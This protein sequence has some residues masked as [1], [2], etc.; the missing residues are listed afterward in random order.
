ME[1]NIKQ[2]IQLIELLKEA[3]ADNLT[4]D[5][6]GMFYAGYQMAIDHAI[7]LAQLK[8]TSLAFELALNKWRAA[9]EAI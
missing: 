8:Q 5:N 6:G 1:S 3:K 2:I 4:R 9:S 7:G